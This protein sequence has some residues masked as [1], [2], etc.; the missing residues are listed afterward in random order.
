MLRIEFFKQILTD[1]GYERSNILIHGDSW[2]Y[3]SADLYLPTGA[4]RQYIL[5]IEQITAI[6]AVS[7]I[8]AVENYH[9]NQRYMAILQTD[10]PRSALRE[11]LASSRRCEK[12]LTVA[13]LLR[14]EVRRAL[15]EI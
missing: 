1:V 9:P 8:E 10:Q 11:R 2:Q 3:W 13:E 12:I 5:Y 15:R 7:A 4:L 14:N 6:E